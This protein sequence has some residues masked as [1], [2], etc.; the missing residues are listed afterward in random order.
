M[1]RY[2]LIATAIVFFVGALA[3]ALHHRS[4]E[5]RVATV[6]STGSPSPP[7]RQAASTFTP[8]PVTGDAPWALSAVPECF[9][10][11]AEARG[12]RRYALAHLPADATRL[13]EGT[14][15]SASDCVA[16]VHGGNVILVRGGERLRVPSASLYVFGRDAGLAVLSRDRERS[17]LR[18]YRPIAALTVHGAPERATEQAK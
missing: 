7:R 2:L 1:F 17:V 9:V 5:L 8:G 3:A 10:Q 4:G 15:V 6:S 16:W 14:T 18:V 12:P 13:S 11:S